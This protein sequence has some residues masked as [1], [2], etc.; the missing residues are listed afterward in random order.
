MV[1]FY[2]VDLGPKNV[3]KIF[4]SIILGGSTGDV[5]HK[6]VENDWVVEITMFV[7]N[8]VL[9]EK[10]FKKAYSK[11]LSTELHND[12]EE[13]K[14]RKKP[15]DPTKDKYLLDVKSLKID[16]LGFEDLVDM[17]GTKSKMTYFL[18]FVILKNMI[19]TFLEGLSNNLENLR[20]VEYR[21][22]NVK[23]FKFLTG[24][25]KVDSIST[26]VQLYNSLKL[27]DGRF[28]YLKL[29]FLEYNLRTYRLE[30]KSLDVLLKDLKFLKGFKSDLNLLYLN[31]Q[32]KS[33][34]IKN[35]IKKVIIITENLQLEVYKNLKVTESRLNFKLKKTNLRNDKVF[36]KSKSN[37]KKKNGQNISKKFNPN[38]RLLRRGNRSQKL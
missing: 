23:K 29:K 13:F 30:D 21:N 19:H 6:N 20:N 32:N 10:F 15:Y 8:L 35:Y 38:I 12:E 9:L 28:F 16:D 11:S 22:I 34:K 27:H 17:Q 24:L 26:L 36:G 18:K 31:V 14:L 37:L 7:K 3:Y 5:L 33:D 2:N 4:K 1:R 25:L